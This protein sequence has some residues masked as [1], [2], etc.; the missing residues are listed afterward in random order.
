MSARITPERLACIMAK[1][2][3]AVDGPKI[4]VAPAE[5]ELFH[6]EQSEPN[7]KQWL[8]LPYPPSSNRYWRSIVINGSVRV[9]VSTEARKYKKAVQSIAGTFPLL[10]GPIGI[11]VRIYRP[12]R[13]GDLGNRIKVLEDALQGVLFANDSQIVRI[14]ATRHEDKAN[15]RAEVAVWPVG[16][17]PT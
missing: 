10:T 3:Y 13:I 17:E 1:P 4:G 11:I 8:T 2:G 15:P 5:P 9:L 7:P 14:E 16:N 12:K 6:V